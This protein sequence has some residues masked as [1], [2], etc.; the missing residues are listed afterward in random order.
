[1]NKN[2]WIVTGRSESGDDYGPEVFD[3]EPTDEELFEWCH[4]K[5][6]YFAASFDSINDMLEAADEAA[7]DYGSYVYVAVTPSTV[8]V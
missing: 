5:D 7:G 2:I 8:T 3:H 1:M 4:G 6:G